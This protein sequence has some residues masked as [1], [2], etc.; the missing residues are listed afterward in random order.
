MAINGGGLGDAPFRP[1]FQDMQTSE[2]STAP[3]A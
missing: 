3:A 2:T 1:P